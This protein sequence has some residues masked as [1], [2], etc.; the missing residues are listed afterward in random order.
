MLAEAKKIRIKLP[1]KALGSSGYHEEIHG[2]ERERERER[3]EIL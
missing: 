1:L 3:T 2:G